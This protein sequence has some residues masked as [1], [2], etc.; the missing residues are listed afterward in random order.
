MP[1]STTNRLLQRRLESRLEDDLGSVNAEEAE[2]LLDAPLSEEASTNLLE[3]VRSP[4][5]AQGF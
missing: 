1:K 2:T 4:Y 3:K 5:T